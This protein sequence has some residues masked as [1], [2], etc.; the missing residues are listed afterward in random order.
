VKLFWTP[1]PEAAD[2]IRTRDP[3]LGKLVL[4]QLSY[5]RTPSPHFTPF[6]AHTAPSRRLEEGRDPVATRAA[7][8]SGSQLPRTPPPRPIAALY[9]SV[10]P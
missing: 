2:E 5:R 6:V 7:Q 1:G 8:P 3:E 10:C 4:Y 9:P